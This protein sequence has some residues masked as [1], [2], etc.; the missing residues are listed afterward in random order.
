MN[1][2]LKLIAAMDECFLQG[3]DASLLLD[4]PTTE[5]QSPINLLLRAAAF[6]AFDAAKEVVE[7]CCP[8]VVS[9]ADIVQ[10]TARD[11]VVLV[12]K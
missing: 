7:D 10:F 8:G 9:C 1:H 4:G 5:K 12:S 6:D 3:C 2:W 11:S